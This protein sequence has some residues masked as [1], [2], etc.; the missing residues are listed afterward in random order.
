M[1]ILDYDY[2]L[3][4]LDAAHLSNGQH[5]PTTFSI[6]AVAIRTLI[7]ENQLLRESLTDIVTPLLTTE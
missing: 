7:H 1:P 3:R 2:I 4:Q 5:G 6:A